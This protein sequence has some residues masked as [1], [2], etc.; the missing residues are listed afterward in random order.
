M[1]SFLLLIHLAQQIVL[2]FLVLSRIPILLCKLL[3]K[4]RNTDRG[5]W[6]FG[7]HPS[8]L[9]SWGWLNFSD[10]PNC[11]VSHRDT[12]THPLHCLRQWG[13]SI[14]TRLQKFQVNFFNYTI[15]FSCIHWNYFFVKETTNVIDSKIL[16]RQ[17]RIFF[18][19]A[20]MSPYYEQHFVQLTFWFGCFCSWSF[21]FD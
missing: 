21:P 11:A 1:S 13:M 18:E 12:D 10:L 9:W 8:K 15:N 14:T 5:V 7:G 17:T 20:D 4:R 19:L 3:R 16:E 2:V 6:L